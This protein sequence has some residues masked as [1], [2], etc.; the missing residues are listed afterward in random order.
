[1][2]LLLHNST[3]SSHGSF[4]LDAN[5]LDY[6]YGL[7]TPNSP[8]NY[9]KHSNVNNNSNDSNDDDDN[10]NNNH[11]TTKLKMKTLVDIPISEQESLVDDFMNIFTFE[12][13][14][15]I[16]MPQYQQM[17][18]DYLVRHNKEEALLFLIHVDRFK[19]LTD[20]QSRFRMANHMIQLFI[21][22][23][24]RHQVNLDHK[25]RIALLQC[26]IKVVDTPLTYFDQV[27]LKVK[28]QLLEESF[29]AFTRSEAF[30]Q[31]VKQQLLNQYH[32]TGRC[33]PLPQSLNDICSVR[34]KEDLYMQRCDI[35]RRV[36]MSED[37]G[38]IEFDYRMLKFLC[39]R[40]SSHLW[41][42]LER[43]ESQYSIFERKQKV[44]MLKV[45]I[46]VPT[47]MATLFCLMFNRRVK[48][49][50]LPDNRHFLINRK[51]T[52]IVCRRRYRLGR[53]FKDR[54]ASVYYSARFEND[55]IYIPYKSFEDKAY[56][57]RA[58][59]AIR[60][61]CHG[62]YILQSINSNMTLVTQVAFV[63]YGGWVP[64]LLTK[65]LAVTRARRLCLILQTLAK[66]S[67]ESRS[68]HDFRSTSLLKL[69]T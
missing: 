65:R 25:S 13:E 50:N 11:T 10:N 51:V 7:I 63:N 31:W 4:A 3:K 2:A 32:Q 43:V 17:Y 29:V 6:L 23:N 21:Y 62:G 36:M 57:E 37:G 15:I 49:N 46:Y 58:E 41:K 22:D 16:A 54:F 47:D 55:S 35:T 39:D 64:D 1:M 40:E 34:C 42:R 61:E 60:A 44:N 20:D 5:N 38:I 59:G 26:K 56:F 45:E 33:I 28:I 14:T 52:S 69:M 12:F 66:L 53:I 30:G 68:V 18:L 19:R 9:L 67:P 27:A 48:D 8:E 24:G